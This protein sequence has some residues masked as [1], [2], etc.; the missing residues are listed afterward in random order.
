[1]K[2]GCLCKKKCCSQKCVILALSHMLYKRPYLNASSFKPNKTNRGHVKYQRVCMDFSLSRSLALTS[3]EQL[4][5]RG[6]KEPVTVVHKAE[7]E[8]NFLI[9]APSFSCNGLNWSGMIA[10]CCS[11]N[12]FL[13][14]CVLVYICIFFLQTLQQET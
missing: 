7:S 4:V 14:A 8:M 13:V 12:R 5:L 6:L 10:S 3:S 2:Y 1:M 9:Q 11:Y